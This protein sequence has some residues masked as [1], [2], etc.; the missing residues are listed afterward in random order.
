MNK[1]S[2]QLWSVKDAT[3]KDF[4]GTLEAIAK[5]GYDGV[6]FAGYGG[7]DADTMK[8]ELDRMNRLGTNRLEPFEPFGDVRL[9]NN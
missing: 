2:V 1:I 7:I 5:M 4:I 8:K 9:S 3:Q 6:E